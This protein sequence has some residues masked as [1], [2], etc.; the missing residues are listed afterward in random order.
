M[1]HAFTCCSGGRRGDRIPIVSFARG[2]T[3]RDTWF[4]Y[5]KVTV[6]REHR[7]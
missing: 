4:R 2:D 3:R 5:R 6:L 7:E 1:T